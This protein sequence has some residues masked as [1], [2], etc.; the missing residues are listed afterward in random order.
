[1]LA[2]YIKEKGFNEGIQQGAMDGLIE[3]LELGIELRFGAGG[4]KLMAAV[5]QI[6]ELARLKTVKEAVKNARDLEDFETAVNGA[7]LH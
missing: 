2:Q 5:R 7:H 4:L 1:M 6:R 3:G